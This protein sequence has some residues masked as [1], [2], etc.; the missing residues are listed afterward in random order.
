M[1][2]F[3]FRY[4]GEHKRERYDSYNRPPSGY[5]RERDNRERELSGSGAKRR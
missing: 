5:R 1:I 4:S 3:W 2:I